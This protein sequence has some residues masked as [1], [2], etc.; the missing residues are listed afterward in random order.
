MTD[1][2]VE[3][4]THMSMQG[5]VKRQRQ[6]KCNRQAYR[7]REWV[8]KN[9][10]MT[11]GPRQNEAEKKL[12]NNMRKRKNTDK[13]TGSTLKKEIMTCGDDCEWE[14]LFGFMCQPFDRWV[15]C[16]VCTTAL[17]QCGIQR[18]LLCKAQILLLLFIVV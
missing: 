3:Q 8:C 1:Q 7:D 12:T 2:G 17:F 14:W 10:Q 9:G 4:T 11:Q 6:Q 13:L 15:T 5:I 16:P 18:E